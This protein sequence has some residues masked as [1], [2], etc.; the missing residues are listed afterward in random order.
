MEGGHRR[1]ILS[2]ELLIEI[3]KKDGIIWNLSLA[4]FCLLL[5][6]ACSTLHLWYV[7]YLWLQIFYRNFAFDFK[8][9]GPIVLCFS[10]QFLLMAAYLAIHARKTSNRVVILKQS[11]SFQSDTADYMKKSRMIAAPMSINCMTRPYRLILYVDGRST[12][13]KQALAVLV[14]P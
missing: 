4:E 10:I 13:A 2:W 14:S 9:M 11:Q 7:F 6:V 1:C 5:E 12:I 3:E 8:C